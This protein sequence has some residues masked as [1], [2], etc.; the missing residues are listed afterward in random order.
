MNERIKEI[1]LQCYVTI[2]KTGLDG[3]DVKTSTIFDKEKF[4]ELIVRECAEVVISEGKKIAD[5][6]PQT[7]HDNY[8]DVAVMVGRVDSAVDY[9]ASLKQH[10]GVEE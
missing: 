3:R 10:F 2:T 7:N 4:A 6:M 5:S 8:L 9:A 1:E